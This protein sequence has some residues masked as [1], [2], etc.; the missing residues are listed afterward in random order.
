MKKRLYSLIVCLIVWGLISCTENDNS[1]KC[2]CSETPVIEILE[3]SRMEVLK[4]LNDSIGG[5]S[6]LDST[7]QKFTYYRL[8]SLDSIASIEAHTNVEVSGNVV[9][10]CEEGDFKSF[11]LEKIN[12]IK[13]CVKEVDTV[14]LDETLFGD[15]IFQ[16]ILIE[17]QIYQPA[18]ESGEVGISFYDDSGLVSMGADLGEVGMSGDIVLSE[19]YFLISS[20]SSTLIY[21]KTQAEA[22]FGGKFCEAI[23]CNE[24]RVR[25]DYAISKNFL[26]LINSENGITINLYK[27]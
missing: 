23:S 8:C 6:M 20:L 14:E 7:N 4:S 21:P 18:C 12:V 11:D 17:G 16:Q 13:H 9:V 22:F 15:W 19:G 5:L 10:G 2:D 26:Q 25:I 1:G 24:T 27:K 3:K